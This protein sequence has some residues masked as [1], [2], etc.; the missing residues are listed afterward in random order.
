MVKTVRKRKLLIIA[1]K[2]AICVLDSYHF[3]K[4]YATLKHGVPDELPRSK[5]R[6][7]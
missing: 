6:G 7:I 3:K 5:L 4:P 1:L 2:I